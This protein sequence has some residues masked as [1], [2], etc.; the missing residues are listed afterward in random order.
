MLCSLCGYS[1]KVKRMT[2]DELKARLSELFGKDD[3]T[4]DEFLARAKELDVTAYELAAIIE[5]GRE[6][7]RLLKTE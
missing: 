2:V 5:N 6:M 4:V 3:V 7:A 1:E